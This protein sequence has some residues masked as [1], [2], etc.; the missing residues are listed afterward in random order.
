MLSRPVWS[1]LY[2]RK[3][4]NKRSPNCGSADTLYQARMGKE[5]SLITTAISPLSSQTQ[6]VIKRVMQHGG[7]HARSRLP[8]NVLVSPNSKQTQIFFL[9]CLLQHLIP[10]LF[11]TIFNYLLD[12]ND[13]QVISFFYN[14]FKIAQQLICWIVHLT[15]R[16]QDG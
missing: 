10:F 7:K 14:N 3:K 4:F 16:D 1:T 5:L 6:T 9:N 15:G 11:F 8:R 2:E 12:L 13:L